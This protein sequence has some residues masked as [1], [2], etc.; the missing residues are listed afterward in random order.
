MKKEPIAIIGMGCRFP[1]DANSHQEFWNLLL[2]GRDAIVDIPADRWNKDDLFDPDYTRLGKLHVKQGGFIKDIDQFD[3]QFFGISPVEANRMDPLQRLM[4]ETTYQ[5][6]ED[7]GLKLDELAGTDT[8]VFVGNCGS[9]YMEIVH[10]YK[11]RENIGSTSN[12]GICSAVV[13]NRVSYVFDLHGPSFTLDTACS[14]A[15]VALHQAC[16]SIWTNESKMA[17][18]GG[19]NAILKPEW[20]MGFSK[21]GFLSPD[22]RCKAFD[23]SANG[24]VRAEGAGAVIL[25]PLSQALA[26]GDK[27]YAQILGSAI[28]EDGKTQGITL[29]NQEAQVRMLQQAYKD[30]GIDPSEVQYVEAHG[31]GTQAGDSREA[32]AIGLIVG[33]NK[34]AGDF[35][36]IGSVKTNLGHL[37]PASGIA[38]LIKLVLALKHRKIPKSLHFKEG[39]PEIQFAEN[40]M[41]VPTELIDWPHPEKTLYAGINSFG[42][43]GA[44]AHAV[45]AEAPKAATTQKIVK[46]HPGVFVLSAKSKPALKALADKYIS[47]LETTEEELGDICYS[48]LIKRTMLEHRLSIV[49]KNKEE[50]IAQLKSYIKDE[51]KQGLGIDRAGQQQEQKIAFVFSGQGPQWWGMGRELL[52]KNSLFKNKII[53]IDG[54]LKQL[55]WLQEEN[56]SLIQELTKT[57]EDSRINKTAIAQPAIFAIQVALYELWRSL[58]VQPEAIVGHSIGEVA[59]SYASGS[60]SLED[61][62]RVVYWRS[63]CQTVLEGKGKMLAVGM[64]VEDLRMELVELSDCINIAAINGPKTVTLS[65]DASAL[66]KLAEKLTKQ[67]IYNTFLRVDVPFHCFLAESIKEEFLTSLGK[68]TTHKNTIPL[69]ST[70]T[71]EEINGIELDAGYWYKNIRQTVEF[72]PAMKKMVQEGYDTFI[73]LSPHPILATGINDTLAEE[74]KKGVSLPSLR[75]KEDE[76]TIFFDTLGKLI[77]AENK[78][79]IKKLLGDNNKYVDLPF[80]AWQKERFWLETEESKKERMGS[81]THP[82]LVGYKR[83]AKDPNDLIWEV[84][85]NP[86]TEP[87]IN[88]HRVQGPMVYPAAGHLDLVLSAAKLSFGKDFVFIENIHF[89][90]ALLLPEEGTAEIQLEVSSD[91]GNYAI[92]SRMR[93]TDAQWKRCSYG[94][95]NHCQDDFFSERV[96][97]EAIKQRLEKDMLIEKEPFYKLL[98]NDGVQLG[99]AFQVVNK[100][101]YNQHEALTEIEVN[102]KIA[103]NYKKFTFQPAMLDGCVH[104]ALIIVQRL[105]TNDAGVFL[106]TYVKKI[107]LY[108]DAVMSDKIWSYVRI[109]NYDKEKICFNFWI[110]NAN[111]ELILEIKDGVCSYIQGTRTGEKKLEDYFYNYQWQLKNLEVIKESA[112][113]GKWLVLQNGN[114]IGAKIKALLTHHENC[115]YVTNVAEITEPLDVEKIIYL[116][117]LDESEVIDGELLE[118]KQATTG[119]DLI[120]LIQRVNEQNINPKI[121]VVTNGVTQVTGSDAKISPVSAPIWGLVRVVMNEYPQ[122]KTKLIDLSFIPE[123]AELENLI[124]ELEL[125]E[126]EEIS[127]RGKDR[128]IHIL[129]KSDPQKIREESKRKVRALGSPYHTVIGNHKIIDNLELREFARR[130]PAEDEVEIKIH[131]SALNFR[132]VMMAMGM[133]SD[134]AVEGGLYGRNFGLECSGE[135]TSVGGQVKDLAIGDKVVALSPSCLGGFTHAKACHVAKKPEHFSYEDAATIMIV[136]LTAY[137]ALS[138]L[139]RMKKGDKVLVHAGAGGVGIAAIKLAQLMGAEVFATAGSEQKHNYLKTLGVSHIFSSRDLTFKDRI[140]EITEGSGV[141]IVVN[142]IAGKAITQSINCLAPYGRFVEIGKRDIYDD[143]RIGLKPFGNNLAYF[144]VDV[145]RLLKQKPEFAGEMIREFMQLFYDKK[146]DAHPYEKFPISKVKDAFMFLSQSKHIGKVVVAMEEGAEIEVL[147]PTAIQFKKDAAYLVTGGCGGFGLGIAAKMAEKGAG[148]LVLMGRSGVKGEEESA[149]IAKIEQQGTKVIIAKGDVTK[150][151]EVKAIIE[152]LLQQKIELKGIIHAATVFDD[153]PLT[154]LNTERYMNV[155]NPKMLGA[156]NLHKATLKDKLDYFVM[157]SSISAVYGNPGQANYAAGNIFLDTFAAYRRSIGLP[158]NT[159]NWGVIGEVGYVSKNDKVQDILKSQGWTAFSMQEA[160]DILERIMLD[161][162]VQQVAINVDWQKVGEFFPQNATS[163]RFGGLTKG[164]DEVGDAKKGKGNIKGTVASLPKEEQKP[165]LV[166]ELQKA[167]ARIFGTDVSK[168]DT[169]TP[170]TNMGLDSLMAAQLRTWLQINLE[171]DYSIMKIMQ[172]HGISQVAEQLL[173]EII[174][175]DSV[176]VTKVA[177]QKSLTDK[178]IIRPTINPNAKMRLFCFPNTGTGASLFAGW[179]QQLAPEVEVCAVQKPGKEERITEKPLTDVG[180]LMQE[181]ADAMLPLLDKPFALF[182]HCGGGHE[183]TY[184]SDYLIKKHNKRATCLFISATVPRT[185]PNILMDIF[186]E[187]PLEKIDEIPE[188]LIFELLKMAEFGED[189]FMNMQALRDLYPSIKADVAINR[190]AVTVSI[191]AT[192]IPVIALAGKNDTVHS[193]EDISAWKDYVAGSFE[194]RVIPGGHHYL[195]E[196][197]GKQKLLEELKLILQIQK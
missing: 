50:I 183:I 166:A 75:R 172:I 161:N 1:G 100:S 11:E 131:A 158:A 54:I 90:N 56:S 92:Y 130:A 174:S 85:L 128:Y 51:P 192:N 49:A 68:V 107:K 123:K 163:E 76:E 134:E 25:K 26:D 70:V 81:Y 14:S 122:I 141:D 133:L 162:P 108:Q 152:Y 28:N 159:I 7:A 40:K 138:Y 132:D 167:I 2:E 3:A 35:G 112:L 4:L 160:G 156:W 30:A 32:N 12:T 41:Q 146:L 63:R 44:N 62:T 66:E 148:I 169:E 65:G 111:N 184:L 140:M 121:Y 33:K 84:N 9:E 38:G 187:V 45:L 93:N 98:G 52:A 82:H 27:I 91:N 47:Y 120:E 48:L 113:Q 106:P 77:I 116:C 109:T 61:A 97:L 178:W 135:I 142:S 23:K 39:N 136:Y 110:F 42:F 46:E 175:A 137:Y 147:P 36:Y 124:K 193:V 58:G 196:A 145:D 170:I 89:E 189:V 102:S 16:K 73:E 64:R 20:F 57:E 24:Y 83:S 59:A 86:R 151:Q 139:C 37:E 176:P 185:K 194:L 94:K 165:A 186:K 157:F 80:Y 31:T 8:G 17:V 126:G 96:D 171:V 182:G 71:G 88:D 150:E 18:V 74:D 115:R 181:I 22:C 104:A 95:I 103:A 72:Y 99:E 173:K 78:V 190:K 6:F 43:G 101:Y 69:F 114:H 177:V 79:E 29:P 129:E 60:L 127:L 15:L 87:Y 125:S 149:L 195:R 21:G 117:S 155:V 144:A 105:L 191:E 19:V 5:A 153:A 168:V 55:G 154:G 118:T 13:A 164:E 10:G 67:D 143:K 53:E 34:K 197:E 119:R 180:K 179:D 188:G